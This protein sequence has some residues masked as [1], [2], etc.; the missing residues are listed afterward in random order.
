[1]SVNLKKLWSPSGTKKNKMNLTHTQSFTY[2]NATKR[3]QFP[4]KEQAIVMDSTTDAHIQDYI[5]SIAAFVKPELIKFASRISINRVC[6]YLANKQLIEELVTKHSKIK[7]NNSILQIRPLIT[8]SARVVMSN[9]CPIIPHT[10][11]ENELTKLGIKL[12]ST[13]SFLRVGLQN[14]AFNHILSFRR[15]AYITPQDKQKLPDLS[16]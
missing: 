10:V 13:I 11:I 5:H 16:R 1:M 14:P 3:F 8:K 6:I 12:R 2:V 9:V 4:T 15:Q 7:V